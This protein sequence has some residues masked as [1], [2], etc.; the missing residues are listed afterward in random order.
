MVVLLTAMGD[1][2]MRML[3]VVL[4][5]AAAA[6]G[7]TSPTAPP[8]VIMVVPTPGPSPCLPDNGWPA[9]DKPQPSP[10]PVTGKCP[11]GWFN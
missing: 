2:I 11:E 8:V 7:A 5:V 9:V 6:C 3:I 4:T 10:D 1:Y